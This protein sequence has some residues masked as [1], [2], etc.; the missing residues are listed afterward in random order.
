MSPSA[1]RLSSPV[2]SPAR[3]DYTLP[4]IFVTSLFFLWG[5]AYGLLDVL[6][7]HFQEAL[8]VGRADSGWLQAAYFGAYFVASFPAG[9]MMQ[10]YGYQRGIM[11]GL[12]LYAAGAFL[13][14]PAA[15]AASFIG[16]L[17]ALFV[18]ACGLS[19]LE[20]AA[21]PYVT[22]LGPPQSA[23]RRLNLSQSFN[24]LGSFIGPLLGG[25]V[26]FTAAAPPTSTGSLTGVIRIYAAIGV[27]V[28]GVAWGFSRL[29]LPELAA[30][31][32]PGAHAAHRLR[33]R[34][35]FVFGVIAQF[36]YVAA[37]VGVGA[38]FINFATEHWAGLTSQRGAY[39]LSIGLLCFL[40][41]RFATTALMGR[42]SPHRILLVYSLACFGL[43]LLTA[44]G[45]ERVSVIALIAVFFFMSIMF[46]TIFSLG[47]KQLG[48]LTKR[49]SSY[50]VAAIVGGAL[51]PYLM[52]LTAEHSSTAAAYLLPAGCF[53]VIIVYAWRGWRV[54]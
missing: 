12:L 23:E 13:F 9:V 33:D 37:Q 16:F 27:L 25:A 52:G 34:P 21:N 15:L 53:A 14:I 24:G 41:G 3:S 30:D 22:V 4:L 20:T 42:I 48:A 2:P 31:S 32:T 50:M 44:A 8:H 7:K 54:R 10:R 11:V 26:F 49:G 51:L 46:P 5:L 18:L 38:F 45:I 47:L 28:L 1:V 43:L 29:A 36:F 35:H 39:L 17:G 6:N 19:C 40:L